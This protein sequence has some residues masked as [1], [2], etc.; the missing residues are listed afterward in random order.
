M[1]IDEAWEYVAT[2][3]I[4][5]DIAFQIL[6]NIN[7]HIVFDEHIG[8]D[9]TVYTNNAPTFNHNRHDSSS[10][11]SKSNNTAIRTETPLVTCR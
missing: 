8:I 5:R 3:C 11:E 4:K 10:A 7:D 9:D 1:Q 2:S 6:A